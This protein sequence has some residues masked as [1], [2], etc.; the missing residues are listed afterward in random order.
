MPYAPPTVRGPQVRRVDRPTAHARGYTKAW[1][2]LRAVVLLEE[3]LCRECLLERAF[4]VDDP[5]TVIIE[6]AEDWRIPVESVRASFRSMRIRNCKPLVATNRPTD[7]TDCDHIQ[8]RNMGGSD[9]RINL[10]GLCHGHHSR[11]TAVESSGWRT[12]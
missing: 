10:Q 12:Q 4:F 11:K 6:I 1:R 8:P 2:A 9:D 3:P 5:E 7:S